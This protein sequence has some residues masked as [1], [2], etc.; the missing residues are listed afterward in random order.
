M[1]LDQM[2]REAAERSL[3]ASDLAREA[4]VRHSYRA[5]AGDPRLY[6]LV[7]DSTSIALDACVEI[8]ALGVISRG[9]RLREPRRAAP[10]TR[11]A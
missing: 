4:Y 2:D 11:T 10:L 3:H 6:Q 9:A 5:D 1:S 8:V 7:I